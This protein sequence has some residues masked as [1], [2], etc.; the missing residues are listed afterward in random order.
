[1]SVQ[2]V[3]TR[4][5]RYKLDFDRGLLTR[6][7]AGHSGEWL[8]GDLRRDGEPIPFRLIGKIELGKPMRLVLRV[9][10]DNVTTLR[11][12]TPVVGLE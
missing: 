7:P 3:R 8:A 2:Y 9:R 6:R 1:M 10:D 12:T 4:T 5:A 11:Y